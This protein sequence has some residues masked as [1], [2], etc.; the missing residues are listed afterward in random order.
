MD[1]IAALPGHRCY[2]PSL[3]RVRTRFGIAMMILGLAH[4]Y[5]WL[6]LVSAAHLPLRWHALA[7]I[8][9]VVLAPSLPVATLALR[10]LP[11][12]TARPYVWL[13]YTGFGFS[14]YLLVAAAVTHL[15]RGI[16][17]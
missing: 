2:T 1:R 13:A 4:Y 8:A 17:R 5:V 12:A 7:T 6:R 9:I 15:A 3:R 14:V 10:R 16:P 11:R